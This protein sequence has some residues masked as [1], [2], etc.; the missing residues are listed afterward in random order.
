S[1][2]T[3]NLRMST[4]RTR[5]RLTGS[6]TRV[7]PATYTFGAAASEKKVVAQGD[8]PS[9]GGLALSGSYDFNC[10]APFL[11]RTSPVSGSISVTGDYT[12]QEACT[13]SPSTAAAITTTR[14]AR[15]RA[16]KNWRL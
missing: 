6:K 2:T 12:P 9:F 7:L 15:S 3:R 8:N 10:Q 13:A 5:W 1:E 4:K 11:P 16:R 14:A